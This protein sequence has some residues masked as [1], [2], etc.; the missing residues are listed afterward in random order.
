MYMICLST[1]CE[2]ALEG[3]PINTAEMPVTIKYGF[4]W[5]GFPL[6]ENMPIQTVF[7][8]IEPVIGDN[9]KS[10]TTNATYNGTSW[11]GSLKN[12]EPGHGYIYHSKALEDKTLFFSAPQNK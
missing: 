9:I 7:A 2:I 10:W 3:L 6:H 11:R 5:I 1:H 12:L 8:G 4:N